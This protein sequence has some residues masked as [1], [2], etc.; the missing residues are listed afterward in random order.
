M[1]HYNHTR[2]E[3]KGLD[4]IDRKDYPVEALREALLNA[5]VHRDYSFSASTLISIFDDRIEFVTVG[6]LVKGITLEDILLG[7]SILRNQNLASIFYRLNLIEAYG[8]G[9][10]KIMECY[11]EGGQPPRFDV[12][13]NAFKVTLPNRNFKLQSDMMTIAE[14]SL[15]VTDREEQVIRLFETQEYI[16]R[17]DVEEAA[18]V[19]QATAIVLLRE[20]T[21]KG[22]LRK[23]GS[24]KFVKYKLGE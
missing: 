14:K 10:P 13:D 18:K 4:R 23:E 2:A 20:M 6:G 5:I 9:V 15:S 1:E 7:V 8:T 22:M 16:V 21:Q 17:K 24:G 19:S 12:T 3:F 11:E